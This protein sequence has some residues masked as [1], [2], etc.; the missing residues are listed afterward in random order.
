M[1]KY[2]TILLATVIW[3]MIFA[4]PSPALGKIGFIST[5]DSTNNNNTLANLTAEAQIP[6]Y[7]SFVLLAYCPP[8][9]LDLSECETL[10]FPVLSE[11]AEI[12][13]RSRDNC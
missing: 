3:H 7:S 12:Y 11:Q 5:T 10:V 13:D 6:S 2:S 4:D 1:Y 8:S 9:S